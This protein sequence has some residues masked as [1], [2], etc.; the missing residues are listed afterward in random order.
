MVASEAHAVRAQ[1][2]K[3]R[4]QAC[5]LAA[6]VPSVKLPRC[7][8][9]ENKRI[10]KSNEVCVGNSCSR[11]SLVEDDADALS[12]TLTNVPVQNIRLPTHKRSARR[13]QCGVALAARQPI[14]TNV[15]EI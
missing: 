15:H 1:K 9:S 8:A 13:I 3:R 10:L 4:M 6:P 12:C 14:E 11:H 2:T 7:C 5:D